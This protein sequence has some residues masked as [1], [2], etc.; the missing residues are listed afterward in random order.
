[1]DFNYKACIEYLIPR[2]S[3][4]KV[5]RLIIDGWSISFESVYVLTRNITGVLDMEGYYASE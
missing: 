3:Q 2:L 4:D 5:E 1:M